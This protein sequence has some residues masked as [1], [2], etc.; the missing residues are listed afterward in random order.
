MISSHTPS[1]HKC[2]TH[3]RK[4]ESV[5]WLSNQIIPGKYNKAAK[6]NPM[7]KTNAVVVL[8]SA[9]YKVVRINPKNSNTFTTTKKSNSL[10]ISR[11]FLPSQILK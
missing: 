2:T 8:R 9:L 3:Q 1:T 7:V 6:T 4:N 11:N 10:G 5:T